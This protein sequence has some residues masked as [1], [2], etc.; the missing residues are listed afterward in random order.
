MGRREVRGW[1][2][3]LLT[4]LSGQW[5]E[6]DDVLKAWLKREGEEDGVPEWQDDAADL[7][8]SPRR[9]WDL[10][11]LCSAAQWASLPES[12]GWLDQPEDFLHDVGVFTRRLSYLRRRRDFGKKQRDEAEKRLGIRERWS[13]RGRR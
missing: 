3:K 1:L 11:A 9:N 5:S 8:V 6:W 13:S 7:L 10:F 12:G 4:R 2:G